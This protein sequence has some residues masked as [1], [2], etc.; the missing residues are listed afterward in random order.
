M[1]FGRYTGG[2]QGHTLSDGVPDL[3]GEIRGFEPLNPNMHLQIA[4]AVW[5]IEMRSSVDR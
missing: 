1:P 5:R 2:V 3:E 4:A